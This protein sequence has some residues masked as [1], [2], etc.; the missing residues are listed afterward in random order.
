[1]QNRKPRPPFAAAALVL[2]L[3]LILIPV[4]PPF[5]QT[6]VSLAGSVSDSRTAAA[7]AGAT[8]E[9]A[10]YRISAVTDA[11]GRYSLGG[12]AALR[13]PLIPDDAAPLLDPRLLAYPHAEAGPVRIR[14]LSLSG[15]ERA[16]LHSG[17]LGKG[18]WEISPPSLPPGAYACVF[19]TPL[20]RRS[21]RFLV[22]RTGAGAGRV[23]LGA[24][25]P[26]GTGPAETAIP[27]AAKISAAAPAPAMDTLRVSKPGY[28]TAR[29]PI[30]AYQQSGLDLVLEDSAA[31]GPEA[32][33]VPNPS[34][35]C[36]MPEGIPA[37]ASG[38]SAFT[39]TLQ[40]G[41][42]RDVGITRFG[43]RRQF[44][45]KGG[46]IAGA[47]INGT[48]LTG[49]LEYELTLA[50]GVTELEQIDIL[51]A[52][53]VPILMRNAGTA[54]AGAANTRV[55][56][57]FEAPNSGSFAWLNTGKFAATRIVDTAAKTV[58]LDVYEISKA[59]A[60]GAR[61]AIKDP[62]GVPDQTWDCFKLAGGQ[63]ASVFTESVTL[64]TS[65]SIGAS[66][67]GSRNIIPI[68]GGTTTGRVTGK[69][70][71]GGADYQLTGLDARYTLAP[72]NGELIIVRNC[73]ANGLVPVFE[74][75]VDGA[76]TFL[77]EN[78]YLSSAPATSGGGV[79]ITFYEKQ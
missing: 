75:R 23:S 5:C 72:D 16:V 77:N 25:D 32:V 8:V 15:A 22:T 1:M 36:S 35:T 40:I 42:V 6:N 76:F 30:L 70:L 57:D 34:W 2:I 64:G 28:R 13:P 59:A 48:V 60:T 21:I 47:R 53:N 10:G 31:T 58:R 12:A 69:I 56:L 39:I 50:N 45:I 73:G 24:T 41:A 38:E 54:P 14:I 55:V 44:D 79:S 27:V 49:G 63:G 52:D 46:T 26:A 17:W 68:T 4:A 66:K 37:P 3:I 19:A 51:R 7:L 67:R 33:F 20:S 11:G 62:A 61:I 65:I 71:N 74:A 18:N 9:L 29:I 78:K 43:H